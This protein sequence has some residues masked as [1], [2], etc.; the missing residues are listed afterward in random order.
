M[1]SVTWRQV[2]RLGAFH[3]DIEPGEVPEHAGADVEIVLTLRRPWIDRF[4]DGDA[5]FRSLLTEDHAEHA[6]LRQTDAWLLASAMRE[7]GCLGRGRVNS[8]Q[9]TVNRGEARPVYCLLFPV[10]VP[11]DI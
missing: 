2:V 10:H 11:R 1:S 6:Q 9:S 7:T 4:D 5:L 3:V 8:E